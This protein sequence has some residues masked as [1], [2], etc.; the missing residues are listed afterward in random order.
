[1]ERITRYK[2]KYVHLSHAWYAPS[3]LPGREFADEVLLGLYDEEGGTAGEL[4]VRW[5]ALGNRMATRLEIF[6]DAWGLMPQLQDLVDQLAKVG[7]STLSPKE[8]CRMLTFCGFE[9]AT[10]KEAPIP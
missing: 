3:C 6:D 4:A 7:G 2:R 9:D 5:Y 10:P 8:F 1:M